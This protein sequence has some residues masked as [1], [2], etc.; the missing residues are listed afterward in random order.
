MGLDVGIDE[1]EKV[2]LL[3]G[4]VDDHDALEAAHLIGREPD[5]GGRIH[6]FGH[7][8]GKLAELVVELGDGLGLGSQNGIG[9]LDNGQK[10]HETLLERVELVKPSILV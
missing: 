7:V 9:I 8:G 2:V 4:D 3:V 6:G 1:D 5:A 10:S